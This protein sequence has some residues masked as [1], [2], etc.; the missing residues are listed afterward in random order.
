M[1]QVPPGITIER[2][3]KGIP[4][5]ARIDLKKYGNKLKDFFASERISME[6]S[7]YN[8]EL[9]AKVRESEKQI[10]EGNYHKLDPDDLW[11]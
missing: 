9:V 11:K 7:P 3:A 2:N 4:T 8:P 1:K 6:K 10:E 5:F